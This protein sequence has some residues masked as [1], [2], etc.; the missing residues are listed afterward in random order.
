MSPCT[1]SAA[2]GR[3]CYPAWTASLFEDDRRRL[4]RAEHMKARWQSASCILHARVV[5]ATMP[6]T[7]KLIASSISHLRTDSRR[8]VRNRKQ[9]RLRWE[10]VL[11]CAVDGV[12]ARGDLPNSRQIR[13]DVGLLLPSPS[14]ELGLQHKARTPN[15]R[16]TSCLRGPWPPTDSIQLAACA[17]PP[18]SHRRGPPDASRRSATQRPRHACQA[19]TSAGRCAAVHSARHPFEAGPFPPG[20]ITSGPGRLAATLECDAGSDSIGMS[21][22]RMHRDALRL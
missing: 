13:A 8:Q 19:S 4:G 20:A 18:H 21:P 12:D 6:R 5:L 14:C 15:G 9:T 10:A 16:R 17:S 11:C 1:L 3:Q 22:T 2:V 7:G